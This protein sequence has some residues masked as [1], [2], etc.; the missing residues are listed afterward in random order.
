MVLLA[1]L[2]AVTVLMC[3][4]APATALKFESVHSLAFD[5]SSGT[6]PAGA[7]A[8]FLSRAPNPQAKL[9]ACRAADPA[10]NNRFVGVLD[11]RN[12]PDAPCQVVSSAVSAANE[13]RA[14]E[15]LTGDSA[16]WEPATGTG[17]NFPV[18]AGWPEFAVFPGYFVDHTLLGMC[19]APLLVDGLPAVAVGRLTVVVGTGATCRV[20]FGGRVYNPSQ[21]DVLASC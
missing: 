14:V 3:V 20:A 6:F 2:A 15:I 18:V 11:A 10:F 5:K 13:T 8:G 1:A 21:F 16:C 19:R 9:Y 17:G 12:G 4:S 7:P